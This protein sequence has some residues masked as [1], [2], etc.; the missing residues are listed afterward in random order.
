MLAGKKILITRPVDQG[1]RL[2]AELSAMGAE[3][4]VIP[5]LEIQPITYAVSLE[6]LRQQDRF[7]FISQNATL[8]G[9]PISDLN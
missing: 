6:K 2:S 7:I 9:P 8:Y 4:C 5:A 3:C 1:K